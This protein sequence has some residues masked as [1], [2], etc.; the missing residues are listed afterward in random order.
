[1]SQYTV[2]QEITLSLKLL[3]TS[4]AA[5]DLNSNRKNRPL[6][7]SA[8]V[9]ALLLSSPWAQRNSPIGKKNNQLPIPI[10]FR[11]RKEIIKPK[12]GD[13][14]AAFYGFNYLQLTLEYFFSFG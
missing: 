14:F 10:G 8:S 2:V 13:A 4:N 7:L 6:H 9:V 1:M 5:T 11:R 3:L 12:K